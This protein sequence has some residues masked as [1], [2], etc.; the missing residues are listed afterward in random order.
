MAPEIVEELELLSGTGRWE[1]ETYNR[2]KPPLNESAVVAKTATE[3]VGGGG[4]RL[5]DNFLITAD[6]AEQLCRY[7]DDFRS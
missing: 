2:S 7:P 5:E 4:L 6:G 3:P 1:N